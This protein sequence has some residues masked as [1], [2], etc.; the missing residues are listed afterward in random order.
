M[1]GKYVP[2]LVVTGHLF[3]EAVGVA[4]D[5]RAFAID[6]IQHTAQPVVGEL[7]AAE[8]RLISGFPGHAADVAVVAGCAVL[9]VVIQVLRELAAADGCQPVAEIAN[10]K[11]IL[12]QDYS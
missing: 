1:Q 5:V 8:R 11:A 7:V 9:G 2:V 12:K 3:G 4:A 6:R 10:K